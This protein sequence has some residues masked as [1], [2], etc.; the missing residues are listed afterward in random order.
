VPV[1]VCRDMGAGYVIGVNVVPDPDKAIFDITTVDK[2]N[3]VV[4]S[5]QLEENENTTHISGPPEIENHSLR[6]R[7]SEI[8]NTANLFLEGHRSKSQGGVTTLP[9]PLQANPVRQGRAKPP[10]FFHVLSQTWTIVEYRIAMDNLKE[11]DLALSP[12]VE[13]IGFWQFNKAAQAIAAGEQAAR[14]VLQ[15]NKLPAFL[16]KN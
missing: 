7:I 1:S 3:S 5:S 14:K 2:P 9:N 11:A 8:E 13:G 6:S 10:G 15:E 16:G 4:E 12:D